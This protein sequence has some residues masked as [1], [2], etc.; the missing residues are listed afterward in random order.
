MRL[1]IFLDP[2]EGMTFGTM[3]EATL[4]AERGGFHGLYRSDHLAPTSGHFERAATEAWTTIAALARET[5]RI[6]L[7]TLVTPLT[8]HAPSVLSKMASTIAEMSGNRVD[9][10][11]GTGWNVGEHEALGLPFEPLGERFQ[12]LEEYIR[13]LLGLWGEEPLTFEG[14]YYRTAGILP[15]PRPSPR[16][17]LIIGG[18]GKRKTPLLAARYADEYNVDWSSVEQCRQFYRLLDE[19]CAEVERD[20]ATIRRSVLLGVIVGEDQSD[21]R[22]AV[23]A[24]VHELGGSDPDE[25]LAEHRSSWRAGTPDQIV[26]WLRQYEAAGTDHAML[27]YAPHTDVQMIDLLAREVLPAFGGGS[28]R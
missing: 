7:G 19:A 27:M 8:F 17:P 24:G 22:R 12:R 14:R 11:I 18:H 23:E 21:V 10:S 5:T 2:Q 3:L 1:S 26:A 28:D 4:A 16:P 25:W 6:R 20:P 15:R 13:V 9:V